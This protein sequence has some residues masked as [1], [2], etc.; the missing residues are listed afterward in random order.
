MS[1]RWTR[2]LS[3]LVAAALGAACVVGG[4]AAARFLH[5]GV[6][7]NQVLATV[8]GNPISVQAFQSEMQRRGG[9]AA[10]VGAPQRRAL[11]DDMIRIQVLA[12]NA[13]KAGYANNP[14]IRRGVSRLLADKYQHDKI[15]EPLASLDVGDGEVEEYYR[16]HLSAFTT[17]ESVHVAAI[18]V[19]VPP[20]AT[21]EQR[22]AL[23]ERAAHVRE[24]AMASGGQSFAELAAQYS[25]D[26]ATRGQGGDLGWIAAG[27]D[28]AHWDPALL[29]AIFDLAQPG[30][31]SPIV[32]TAAGF[33]VAQLLEHR[34][35]TVRPFAEVRNGLRPQL[36][37][38][39]R[40]RR[41]AKLYAAAL[42]TVPVSVNEAGVAA[43]EAAAQAAVDGVP[44]E[45]A[46][47]PG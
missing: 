31:I 43:M 15:D 30:Q 14:E 35:R 4:Q 13:E 28:G 46:V 42:A 21:D 10:F 17:P 3:L 36:I 40:Q 19:A 24:I 2:A 20:E 22:Q 23:R 16:T 7:G 29:G 27:A 39:E 33:Y 47:P 6:T 8:G 26:D 37:R 45:A 32:P 38:E 18:L 11:L 9:E 25:D 34:A 5:R 1:I 41:A 44:G 12:D